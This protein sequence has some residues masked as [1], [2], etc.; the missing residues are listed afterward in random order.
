MQ[1]TNTQ[2]TGNNELYAQ[3]IIAKTATR[4]GITYNQNQYTGNGAPVYTG[5]TATVT[6][7]MNASALNGILY[8]ISREIEKALNA[9]CDVYGVIASVTK[10]SINSLDILLQV[11]AQYKNHDSKIYDAFYTILQ[12]RQFLQL[13]LQA[14]QY[15]IED[16]KTIRNEY[17][18]ICDAVSTHNN[19]V[20]VLR[21]WNAKKHR[22]HIKTATANVEKMVHGNNQRHENNVSVLRNVMLMMFNYVR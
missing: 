17:K 12:Y 18:N 6:Y 14:M 13:Q 16:E 8:N 7:T 2:S 4:N 1:H 11:L 15:C 21:I 19:D 22:Q 5:N 20:L 3:L 10:R 9:Q